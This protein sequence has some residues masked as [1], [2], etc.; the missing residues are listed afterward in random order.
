MN[1]VCATERCNPSNHLSRNYSGAV[2]RSVQNVC[3]DLFVHGW[4]VR[5]CLG[6]FDEVIRRHEPPF[7]NPADVWRWYHQLLFFKRSRRA[8]T[9]WY[10]VCG[11]DRYRRDRNRVDRYVAVRRIGSLVRL[12]SIAIVLLGIAGLRLSWQQ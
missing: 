7:A 10:G 9:R 8:H 2:H 5:D 6:N 11:L 3:L 4:P 12:V 1:G